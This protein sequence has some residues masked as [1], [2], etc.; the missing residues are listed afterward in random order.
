MKRN[1]LKTF[2]IATYDIEID[3]NKKIA[4][5]QKKIDKLNETH[6]TK[7]LKAHKD[8]LAK[9]KD[10]KKDIVGLEEKTAAREQRI[11]GAVENKIA[12]FNR[13]EQTIRKEHND[14]ITASNEA[15]HKEQQKILEQ[16]NTIKENEK[17]DID[18]VVSKYRTNVESY[19]EKLDT[20]NNNFENNRSLLLADYKQYEV[21]L[22]NHLQGIEDFKT[23]QENLLKEKLNHFIETKTNQNALS[24][25][26]KDDLERLL[27][28]EEIEFRHDTNLNVTQI[29]QFINEMKEQFDQHYKAIIKQLKTEKTA[30][31]NAF[32]A[33]QTLIKKD[34][35]LNISKIEEQISSLGEA[36]S[37]KLLKSIEMKRHLFELRAST[38]SEYEETMYA[39]KLSLLNHEILHFEAVLKNE[40][41]NLNKLQVFLVNDQIQL[42]DTVLYF[43]GVNVKLKSDLNKSEFNNNDYLI[44]HEN[45]KNEFL[46]NYSKLFTDL[47]KRLVIANQS[48]LTQ[49]S[50]INSELDDIN[51]FLDT[52]EPLKEIELNKLRQSIEVNEIKE[53]YNI[54]YAKQDHESRILE[55][56]MRTQKQLKELEVKVQIGLNNTEISLIKTKEVMDK[57]IEKAK[58]K[59]NKAKEIYKLRQNSTKLERNILKSSYDTEIDKLDLMKD[60]TALEI[61]KNNALLRK[62]LENHIADL[63]VEHNY[64]IEVIIKQSEEDLLK[65]QEQTSKIMNDR[66]S[67]TASV[68]HLIAEEES[69]VDKVIGDINIQI[70]QKLQLVEEAL[71]REIKEPSLNIARSEVIIKERMAK[72][73][74]NDAIYTEFVTSTKE[75]LYS[76]NL[77]P[78]QIKQVLVK[79]KS[80]H[81]KSSKY[82]ENA[83]DILKEA[84]QFMNELEQRRLQHKESST[85]DQN[86]LKKL[87]KQMQKQELEY[88][89]QLQA[90]DV[91]KKE[92]DQKINAAV[93]NNIQTILKLKNLTPESLT[94]QVDTIFEYA[95]K[96]LSS[97][98]GNIIKEVQLL[99][100]P[101]TKTDQEILDNASKN[102]VRTK[103][104]IEKERE[105][106]ITPINLALGEFIKEKE[107]EK[108]RMIDGYNKEIAEINITI[109]SIQDSADEKIAELQKDLDELLIIQNEQL[110]V[111]ANSIQ[112]EVEVQIQDI[113]QN[114][115]SLENDYEHKL[116]LLDEK[117]LEAQKIVEYEERIY[118]IAIETAE[119]RYNEAVIKVRKT[120]E[121]LEQDVAKDKIILLSN[122][123]K[124]IERINKEL[125]DATNEFE[126]NIFTT[127]PR[128]EESIGDARKAIED[129]QTS[130]LS[131]KE[132]LLDIKQKVIESIEQQLYTS[133]K[134]G[135]ERLFE[136]LQFYLEKYKI[137]E[138]DYQQSNLDANDL[139]TQ[140]QQVFKQSLFELSKNK[141]QKTLEELLSINQQIS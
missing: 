91:A 100:E 133:F 40:I 63:N 136:N 96:Q 37:K 112:S 126:K 107:A 50:Q 137:I 125:V 59:F 14:Y 75:M 38:T 5:L 6:E 7:S 99:Y 43:K 29:Q 54:K 65:Y 97:I 39:D 138:E 109:S 72:F 33:R 129:E 57:T 89:R 135:Y 51:K 48:Q 71:K 124:N 92:H 20:Y 94:Q 127:R 26:Q 46:N 10:S 132:D 122:A 61:E 123:E 98:Q 18:E 85:T 139:I 47:K 13:K 83:Y 93:K 81:D 58:L 114:K 66:D 113:S 105:A 31:Q 42:K 116:K 102:A 84:I 120:N 41:Y 119:S 108:H 12:V 36:K 9:E 87:K 134:E 23:N 53:R 21:V 1:D 115:I 19:I 3:F 128:F 44:K 4:P 74:T 82:I 67:F 117:D 11:E 2:D 73:T 130:K 95:F 55:N 140:T 103:N 24:K 70:D 52:A 28:K 118:N 76:D 45:L 32:F 69:R 62:E 15:Y 64:K 79:N 25:Q 27:N 80:I 60:L 49:L 30:L 77:T 111:L 88:K 131:R 35:E 104:M 16:V 106:L 34:L 86:K 101:L 141:H 110:A 121:L 68:N 78:E 17:L 56:E 8:F 90:I 22:N